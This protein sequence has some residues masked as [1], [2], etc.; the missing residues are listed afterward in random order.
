[1]T[2]LE[3][4]RRGKSVT[5]IEREGPDRFG[6]SA[7]EAFGGLF[8]VDSPEQRRMGIKFAGARFRRLE[9]LRAIRRGR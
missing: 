9:R 8:F 4:V 2:A 3:L 5:L 7:L 1:M 6:G